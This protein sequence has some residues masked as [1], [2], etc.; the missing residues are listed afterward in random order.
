M[1][2]VKVPTSR[3]EAEAL[4]QDDPLSHA[5]SAFALP[6][7]VIYLD[8]HSLGPATHAALKRVEE[9]AGREWKDGLI[10]SWN[11]AG[12]I[13]LPANVGARLAGLLG[14][15]PDEIIICDSV[16][17]NLFKLAAA[18]MRLAG[19][20]TILIE[21]SEFPTD[22]YVM[23]GLAGI[24]GAS[25]KRVGEGKG[26]AA[27]AAETAVL[28]K[29]VVNYRTARIADMGAHEEAAKARG[30]VVVW[31]LSHAA[32]VVDLDLTAS[33]AWMAAGCTYKFLN[34]GPGAPAYVFVRGDLA[35]RIESPI[36]GW[37]GHAAPFA[38]DAAYKPRLGVARFAAGTPGILS[39]A[40]LDGALA[41]FN[42]VDPRMAALKAARLGDL[43][44]A[45]AQAMGLECI[46]PIE[47]YLR[48][49]HVS[50]R[51]EEGYAVVQA[52]I[53]A[54]V[55]ADFRAPDAMRFGVSPLFLRYVDV[56]DAMDALERVLETRAWDKPEFK[57][58]AAV[59]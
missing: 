30:G 44:V 11:D 49:G 27:L 20:K 40:A 46:S 34:G 36:S 13:D 32:G 23:E 33:G 1:A 18:A 5:R 3:K 8:G 31:D 54:K 35:T 4:D 52:L 29:S 56:W 16:S 43:V 12:W 7:G 6:E 58:R 48:G 37:M 14:A 26:A 45:R 59:T 51:H 24:S 15:A 41:A 22:Q 17:V 57:M 9:V 28:V 50:V 25:L 2:Q 10:R 21:E 39:L 19:T 42:G 38:F 53:A 55:I 47:G